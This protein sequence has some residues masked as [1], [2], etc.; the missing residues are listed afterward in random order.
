MRAAGDFNQRVTIEAKVYDLDTDGEQIYVDTDG[1]TLEDTWEAVASMISAQIMPI[2]G[3]ELIAAAAVQ[4][5]VTTRIRIRYRPG[6]T[7][8]MRVIH[9]STTYGIEAVVPDS[10]GG[11]EYLTLHCTSGVADS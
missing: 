4:S 10:D 7:A 11:F 2:S 9:R 3:G 5:K 6:I 8:A 1:A